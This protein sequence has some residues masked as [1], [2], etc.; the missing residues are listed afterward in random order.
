MSLKKPSSYEFVQQLKEFRK[1]TGL[2]A[3]ALS[4]VFGIGYPSWH[5]W[6]NGIITPNHTSK[7]LL[8]LILKH[9]Q[10]M[11]DLISDIDKPKV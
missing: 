7:T 11:A 5:D 1:Q 8:K 9:P 10:L 4:R 2:S 6:E 3:A